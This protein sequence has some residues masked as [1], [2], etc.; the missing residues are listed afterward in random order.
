MRA[1]FAAT[2]IQIGII[3]IVFSLDSVITAGVWPI[4]LDHGHRH[5]DRDR[6]HD[7]FRESVGDYVDRHTTIKMLALSFLL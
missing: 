1:G 4:S 7:V 3:D 5:R 6:R 2:I